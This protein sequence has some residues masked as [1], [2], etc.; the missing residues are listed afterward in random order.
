MG[1][2]ETS[3]KI[4][5]ERPD[6]RQA[7]HDLI[8]E[9][10]ATA[11]RSDGTEQDLVEALRGNREAFVPELSLVAEVDGELAGHILFTRMTVGGETV[12]AL[13]PLSVR[14]SRQRQ[15]IG[16][17]LIREGHRIAAALGYGYAVVL[18]S[19]GYYP[20]AGYRPARDFSIEPPA[21]IPERNYMAIRLRPHAKPI[22]G[23][24]RYAKEFGI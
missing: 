3:V 17:A 6:D 16:T 15:G 23:A 18:G 19:E 14:P 11:A 21:G 12:L 2:M 1:V 24:V 9:A 8:R 7:V 20:R 4:R 10:F 13:A 5:R 22:R